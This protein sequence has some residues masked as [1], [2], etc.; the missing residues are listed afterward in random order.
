MVAR[1]TITLVACALLAGCGGSD[2]GSGAAS[3]VDPFG[4]RELYPPRSAPVAS[5]GSPTMRT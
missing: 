3:G 5:G 2:A 1:E 4:V